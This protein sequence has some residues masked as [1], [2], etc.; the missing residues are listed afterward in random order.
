VNASSTT[1]TSNLTHITISAAPTFT[2]LDDNNIHTKGNDSNS[3]KN[4]KRLK[5]TSP[6][7]HTPDHAP[8]T[9]FADPLLLIHEAAKQLKQMKPPL[10]HHP[11]HLANSSTSSSSSLSLLKPATS[12][13]P[14]PSPSSLQQDDHIYG[15]GFLQGLRKGETQ[16]RFGLLSGLRPK[17][18]DK[19]VAV[20]TVA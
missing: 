5:M 20:R 8:S 10:Q 1:T 2:A 11:S 14:M 19:Y 3:D 15:S 13:P 4:N 12:S 7:A 17:L 6:L 9:S 18:M 16:C